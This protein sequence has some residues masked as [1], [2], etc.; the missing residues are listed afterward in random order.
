MFVLVFRIQAV[1]SVLGVLC[2]LAATWM[3]AAP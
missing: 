2:I 3:D 1:L